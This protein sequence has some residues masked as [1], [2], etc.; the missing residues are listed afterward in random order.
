LNFAPDRVEAFHVEALAPWLKG[1]SRF[2]LTTRLQILMFKPGQSGNPAG[3]PKGA[4]NKLEESFLKDMLADWKDNG[5]TAIKAARE[6]DPAAY[7]KVVASLLPKD[8][9]LNADLSEAFVRMLDVI[10]NDARPVAA[11]VA[12]Q[13]QQPAPV[14]H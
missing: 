6:D 1:S 7:L 13:P 5:P 14:R 4:R 8:I 3:R 11:G 10:S 9:N 2:D 12:E